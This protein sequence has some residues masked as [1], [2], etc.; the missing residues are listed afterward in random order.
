VLR[1]LL[2]RIGRRGAALLMFAFIDSVYA[3]SLFNPLPEYRRTPTVLFL[4]AV[5]PLWLWGVLWA[6]SAVACFVCAFLRHDRWGFASAMAMKTLWGLLFVFAA[7]MGLDR[8][9]VSA[10]LWLAM[11]GWVGIISTWPEPPRIPH[12][13]QH[14]VGR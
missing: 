11:A 14:A 8:A 3:F 2:R 7:F 6:A 12:F 1:A 5:A 4:G 13:P 10:A 9:Y